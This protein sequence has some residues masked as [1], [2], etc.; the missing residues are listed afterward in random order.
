MLDLFRKTGATLP[1]LSSYVRCHGRDYVVKLVRSVCERVMSLP[2]V[3]LAIQRV[4]LD[5]PWGTGKMRI[6][7]TGVYQP[8]QRSRDYTSGKTALE[9]ESQEEVEACGLDEEEWNERQVEVYIIFM[10]VGK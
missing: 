3:W 6:F 10:F 9:A 7:R 5:L 4:E 1:Y 2:I 8:F